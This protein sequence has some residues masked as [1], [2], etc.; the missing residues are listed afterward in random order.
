VGVALAAVPADASAPSPSPERTYVAARAA[1]LAG[2]HTRSARLLARLA[3][4][5]GAGS[6]IAK[7]A[8]A[9]AISAGDIGLAQRLAVRVPRAELPVEARLLLAAGEIRARRADRAPELL[10]GT[11]EAT[12]F[13]FLT[14]F[15][16][17][18]IAA[19]RGDYTRAIAS[20]NA[21]DQTNVLNGARDEQMALLLLKLRRA[22]EADPYARRAVGTAGGREQ[23]LRLALAD[24]F[25]A[26]GDPARARVMA[27]GL[28]LDA[29]DARRRIEA[30][31]RTGLAVDTVALAYS[32]LLQRLAVELNQLGNRGLA[33]GLTQIARFVAPDNHSAALMLGI[34]LQGRD[35]T[36]DA[37][38][39][40]RSVPADSALAAQ[41]LDLQARALSESD[42]EQE[43]LALAQRAARRPGAAASD[44][45]RLGDVLSAMQ[46]H[47]EA[48]QAYALA[49]AMSANARVDERWPLYLLRANALEQAGRWQEAKAS[50]DVAL[51]LAPDQP[52]VLNFFG[53]GKLERGENLDAAEAMIRKASQLAPEDASITDSLGWALYKRGRLQEAIEVLQ[54]AARGDPDQAEIQEH[55]GDALYKAGRKFE[56]RFAWQ[57]ALNTAEDDIAK[58][59]RAKIE[60]GLTE[61]TAAP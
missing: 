5:P 10:A 13:S 41:S 31:R 58:R 27:A 43:A 3:E 15:V 1:A 20:M 17:A 53:Y 38:A 25:L 35:R 26:A 51:Q 11:T 8:V 46:R 39:A 50:L 21:V 9:E 49:I 37:L 40:F 12:D 7:R 23:R 22:A 19:E 54:R 44:H 2:D 33:V 34:M 28:G 42:R 47:D 30:G 4:Q 57:A 59:V 48:A 56:A 18:W 24:G 14:P 6:A 45:A 52:L 29:A 60:N 61:A 32:E 55:L 16:T 36:D